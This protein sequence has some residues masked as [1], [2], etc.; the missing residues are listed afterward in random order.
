MFY[1]L[2]CLTTVEIFHESG[3][4][5]RDVMKLFSVLWE[6]GA[7]QE[8]V[9]KSQISKRIWSPIQTWLTKLRKLMKI[10][11]NKDGD[12]REDNKYELE[13]EQIEKIETDYFV[14]RISIDF[15]I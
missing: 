4:F 11:E 12:W 13:S 2:S 7:N 3:D 15:M 8:A 5:E 10:T 1:L 14:Q 6:R 9:N